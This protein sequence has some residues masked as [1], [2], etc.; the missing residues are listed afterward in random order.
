M[1]V[2]NNTNQDYWFGPLHIGPNASNVFVDDTSATSLYLTD[3]EV[4]DAIN[5]LYANNKI[6][7]TGPAVPFPR[8][9]GK[10][11]LLHGDGSPEGLVYASEGSLYLR[12]DDANVY[13]KRSMVHL[14]VG[15][16]SLGLAARDQIKVLGRGY[17]GESFPL[18]AA[19][20][21]TS[22]TSGDCRAS[23]VGLLA[24]DRVTNVLFNA[25][26]AISTITTLKV[27]LFDSAGNLLA[28]SAN[29]T[30][31]IGAGTNQ[32]VALSTPYVAPADGLYYLGLVVVATT[33]GGLAAAGS[34]TGKEGAFGTGAK[35][36]IV[37]A[38]QT[39]IPA[40]L[41]TAQTD[42]PPWFGWN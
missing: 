7:V 29:Q 37:K 19:A 3:D 24:G 18:D 38:G 25:N 26:T 36:A 21:A 32:S 11:D 33:P 41:G 14:N 12:R 5:Y 42:T 31:N 34:A 40:S 6:A 39:D 2:T 8:P 23:A 15:W 9:T 1:Q 27:G 16:T 4:A 13:Q 10:P 30:T 17:K 22:F 28:S 20:S 35:G